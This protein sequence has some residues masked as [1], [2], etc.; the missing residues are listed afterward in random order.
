[1][2]KRVSASKC[3]PSFNRFLKVSLRPFDHACNLRDQIRVG[4][5]FCRTVPGLGDLISETCYVV[6]IRPGYCVAF[7]G[8]DL[9]MV[10]DALLRRVVVAELAIDLVTVASI[11]S[12]G[13]RINLLEL[14]LCRS[15]EKYS[16]VRSVRRFPVHLSPAVM[17][18]R[19]FP[20]A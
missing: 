14:L 17:P 19:L 2:R 5:G 7:G 10:A 3:C 8:K 4:C 18:K 9:R 20:I 6:T 13:D 12:P 15:S 1:M 11:R 16:K